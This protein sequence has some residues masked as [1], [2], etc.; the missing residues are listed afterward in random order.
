MCDEIGAAHEGIAGCAR[1][2]RRKDRASGRAADA[3]DDR[4]A[5]K[6]KNKKP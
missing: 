2:E 4:V 6:E 3:C 5:Y 1:R